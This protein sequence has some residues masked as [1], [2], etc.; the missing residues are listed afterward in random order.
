LAER[1]LLQWKKKSEKGTIAAADS[2][3]EEGSLREMA[4]SMV[5]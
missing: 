5:T 4:G 1:A 3:E 2:K